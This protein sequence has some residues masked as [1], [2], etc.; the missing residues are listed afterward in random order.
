LRAL[1]DDYTALTCERDGMGL[2]CRGE[3]GEARD[4]RYWMGCGMQLDLSSD[5]AGEG[6]GRGLNC[7]AVGLG[8][9]VQS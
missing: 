3:D 6:P 5:P 7:S 4:A 9:V 2:S 8:V 1:R